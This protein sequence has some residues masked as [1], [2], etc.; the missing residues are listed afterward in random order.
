MIT[1]RAYTCTSLNSI[2]W[3]AALYAF[4]GNITFIICNNGVKFTRIQCRIVIND[5]TYR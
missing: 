2:Y 5:D 3:S 4:K 1:S